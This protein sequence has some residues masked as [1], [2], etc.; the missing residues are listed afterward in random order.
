MR[1]A[2][3]YIGA[4]VSGAVAAALLVRRLLPTWAQV[5]ALELQM[6]TLQAEQ[7]AE[8]KSTQEKLALFE[9]AERKLTDTFKAL[10]ADALNLNNQ[11]FL[12]LAK[13]TLEKM[14]EGQRVDLQKREATMKDV[15]QPVKESLEKVDAKIAALEQARAGAYASL[16]EQVKQ[17]LEANVSL[18]FET[19]GLASALKAPNLR[20]KWGELQ[21]RR[22]VELAGMVAHCDF[23]E[24]VTVND[25]E[26]NQRPDLV[27]HLPAG[28]KIV[29]DAKAP[30][31]GYLA[32]ASAKSEAERSAAMR[33][34]VRMLRAHVT[35]LS[36]KAYWEQFQPAPE[37][38]ILFLA[39]E[40][41]YSAALTEDPSLLEEA[42]NA[43]V[44]I[45]TPTSLIAMLRAIAF[46][47]RQEQIAINAQ[48]IS[49]LGREL[50]KRVADM[51]G[52]LEGLGTH[53]RKSVDAYNKTIHSAEQRVLVTARKFDSLGAASSHVEIV[54]PEPVDVVPRVPA[55]REQ[56]SLF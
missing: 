52:N 42:A 34:H 33:D 18:R 4:F 28:R 29:I 53:L 20:G 8:R 7:V 17:L 15:V 14:S 43:R 13:V 30:W 24:Q 1:D 54:S 5:R 11:A 6:A 51:V 3:L 47:W 21:L 45:A 25:G 10:S 39:G 55:R 16:S 41:L 19:Q 48:E 46:G 49:E 37:M 40:H 9:Q 31:D 26:R 22:V 50:H 44:V 27:V 2:L 12:G 38:V 36:R 56:Q 23:S 35:A 32:A